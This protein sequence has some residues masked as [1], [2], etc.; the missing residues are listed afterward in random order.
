MSVYSPIRLN[1]FIIN[2]FNLFYPV[3]FISFTV[4]ILILTYFTAVELMDLI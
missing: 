1:K 4:L 2:G 3:H